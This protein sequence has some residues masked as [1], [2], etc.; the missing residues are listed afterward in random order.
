MTQPEASAN[1]PIKKLPFTMFWKF[2]MD[3]SL[4]VIQSLILTEAGAVFSGAPSEI[5]VGALPTRVGAPPTRGGALPTK[6]GAFPTRVAATNAGSPG[7][8]R[9]IPSMAFLSTAS[10]A[11]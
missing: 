5:G 9:F 6:A 1:S 10:A 3:K 7:S 8:Y 4:D 11:S 2:F